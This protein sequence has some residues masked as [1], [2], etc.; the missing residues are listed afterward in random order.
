MLTHYF[1]FPVPTMTSP[2]RQPA[3]GASR[4]AMIKNVKEG[5]MKL[6]EKRVE[7]MK[8]SSDLK[9]RKVGWEC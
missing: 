6:R 1:Y 8:A 7:G 3:S 2:A 9:E 5:N 4:S